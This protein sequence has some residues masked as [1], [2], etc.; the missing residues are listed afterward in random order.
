MSRKRPHGFRGPGAS[1]RLETMF[2]EQFRCLPNPT[3]HELFVELIALM[4]VEVAHV[5]LLGFAG[6]T[7]RSE[8]PRKKATFT[9]FVKQ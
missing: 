2:A 3:R 7:G 6:G 9:Y 1:H 4:D 5:L 8:A